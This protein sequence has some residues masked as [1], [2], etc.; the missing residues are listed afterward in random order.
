MCCSA[1]CGGDDESGRSSCCSPIIPLNDKAKC[2]NTTLI[3][4]IILHFIVLGVK[5]YFLGIFSI[6]T[7][8][9]AVIILWVAVCR[10]DYCLLM[11]YIVLNLFEVFALIVVLGYYLQTDMGQNVP[12][13]DGS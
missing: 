12:N 7:D 5:G 3:V 2:W 1:C 9:A 6:I 8:L 10:Y 4:I 13:T 11:L